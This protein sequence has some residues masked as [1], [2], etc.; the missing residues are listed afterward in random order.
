MARK[1]LECWYSQRW[2][3]KELV[4]ADDREDKS[5]PKLTHDKEVVH[6]F[7]LVGRLTVGEKRNFCAARAKGEFIVHFDSDDWSSP[8][9]IEDQ[10]ARLLASGKFV[11]GYHSMLFT[12]GSSW[13]RYEGQVYAGLP[14]GTNGVFGTSLLY[15]KD[16][17]AGH[18]FV[19]GPQNHNNYEDQFFVKEALK[20]GQL[21][22]APAMDR[23]Y[24]RV[25]P[26]NTSPKGTSN[27]ERWKPVTD[28]HVIAPLLM[29][30]D[31]PH[32]LFLGH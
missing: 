13:W 6:Y 25:H 30:R 2:P 11:T 31:V 32:S 5:F 28:P 14:K 20:G 23:M 16:W 10:M 15:R 18:P 29:G 7:D 19:D 17:W 22:D 27:R 12:D 8:D 24:A 1:A 26:G 9:R 21:F 4:I 3:N